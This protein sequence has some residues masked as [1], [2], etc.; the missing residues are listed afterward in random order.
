[1]SVVGFLSDAHGNGPA[2]NKALNVLRQ[3]GAT[4]IFFLGDALGYIPS[5]S[6]LEL[7]MTDSAQVSCVIGNHDE[8]I[9]RGRFDPA[10]EAIYQHSALRAALSVSALEFLAG[11][12][13][14]RM[15]S[16]AQASVLMVHG[17]PANR[18]N[19]YLY[20]DSALDDAGSGAD[21]IFMGH[22]HRPFIRAQARTTYVNVGSCGM[23]RDDGRFGA[24]ALFDSEL[25]Q[26]RVLRFDITRETAMALEAAGPVS[27]AVRA[28][29]ARRSA[30]IFGEMD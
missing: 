20:P 26:A 12:P 6:A 10:K 23:P 21:F 29:F 3:H 15:V 18:L 2:L 11:W 28:N 5:A 14:F 30:E 22:T 4:Q 13:D 25:R 24:V 7:L 19:G 9:L 8:A 16:I 17:S 1:M 27:V